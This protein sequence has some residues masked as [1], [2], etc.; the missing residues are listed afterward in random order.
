MWPVE[1]GLQPSRAPGCRP[2]AVYLFS[3]AGSNKSLEGLPLGGSVS[4]R[5]CR[6][7]CYNRFAVGPKETTENQMGETSSGK[8]GSN[9]AAS[10]EYNDPFVAR[11]SENLRGRVT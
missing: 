6:R 9:R 10:G 4:T 11:H 1:E 7:R 8:A 5:L 3:L 2:A